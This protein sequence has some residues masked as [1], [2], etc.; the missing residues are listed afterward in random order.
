ML[1]KTEIYSC[2]DRKHLKKKRVWMFPDGL[3]KQ[4]FMMNQKVNKRY[5]NRNVRKGKGG[6]PN[7]I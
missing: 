2:L 5:K 4:N 3:R 1:G 6:I 7:F